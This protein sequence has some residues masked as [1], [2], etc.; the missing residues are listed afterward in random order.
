MDKQTVAALI[1]AQSRSIEA[2]NPSACED[3]SRIRGKRN[4]IVVQPPDRVL[5]RSSPQ[6][7]FLCGRVLGSFAFCQNQLLASS[8]LCVLPSVR[9]RGT[10]GH[11]LDEFFKCNFILET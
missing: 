11:P 4:L 1:A 8:Y 9:P 7:L 2:I 3:V 5:S 10:A 6:F